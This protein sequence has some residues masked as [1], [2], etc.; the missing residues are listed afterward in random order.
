MAHDL[1]QLH[2]VD[3]PAAVLVKLREELSSRVGFRSDVPAE[4]LQVFHPAVS[5]LAIHLELELGEVL[6][7]GVRGERAGLLARPNFVERHAR[8]YFPEAGLHANLLQLWPLLVGLQRRR[9]SGL[10]GEPG[11]VREVGVVHGPRRAVG[12]FPS[13]AEEPRGRD[14]L[15]AVLRLLRGSPRFLKVNV[16]A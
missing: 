3:R 15:D 11:A 2:D 8:R 16:A 7:L 6:L 5:L 12:V 10:G 9:G 1:P 13:V 14:S 4:V